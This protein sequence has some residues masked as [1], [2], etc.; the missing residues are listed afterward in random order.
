MAD[1]VFVQH[2]DFRD[3]ANLA[4]ALGASY[5]TSYIIEGLELT[6]DLGEL[7]VDVDAGVLVIWRGEME[8][9]D[10]RIEP[11]ETRSATAHVVE[12]EERTGLD[13]TDDAVNHVFVDATIGIS[14]SPSVEVNTSGDTPSDESVKIGEVDTNG[15]D[16]DD[17]VAEQWYL[18]NEDATL[19]FPDSDALDEAAAEL[20]G[21]TIVYDRDENEHY[22]VT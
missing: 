9:A 5:R 6:A 7:D 20:R 10:D 13:L 17:A 22:T 14:D 2:G 8:T 21:G 18:I 4:Q 1:N 12:L 16:P 15:A 11:A 19:T 3:A